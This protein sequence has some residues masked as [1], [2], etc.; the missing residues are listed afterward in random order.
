MQ[1][2]PAAQVRGADGGGGQGGQRPAGSRC[3][4]L[5]LLPQSALPEP[6]QPA[7]IAVRGLEETSSTCAHTTPASLL[8]WFPGSKS[9]PYVVLNIGYSAGATAVVNQNLEPQWGETFYLFVR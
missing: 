1:G 8:Q 4:P 6:S 7:A 3:E 5:L 2:V 9:D